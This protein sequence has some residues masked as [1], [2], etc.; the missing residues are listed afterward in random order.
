MTLT[1]KLADE[2]CAAGRQGLIY[3]TIASICG[4]DINEI[5]AWFHKGSIDNMK[6]QDSLERKVYRALDTGCN[7]IIQDCLSVIYDKVMAKGDM[8]A[9]IW[10]LEKMSPEMYGGES[11]GANAINEGIKKRS[12]LRSV[13]VVQQD[14]AAAV[15]RLMEMSQKKI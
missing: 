6:R 7:K 5:M 8:Q 2:I 3:S 11:M 4:V 1:K 10:L 9:A 13:G 14:A 15:T 12:R